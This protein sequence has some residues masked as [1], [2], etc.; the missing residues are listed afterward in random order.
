M[1]RNPSEDRK[2]VEDLHFLRKNH[3][4][5]S[6]LSWTDHWKVA[7]GKTFLDVVKVFNV[8]TRKL[9][10]FFRK[11]KERTHLNCGVNSQQWNQSINRIRNKNCQNTQSVDATW[12]QSTWI[13]GWWNE[14]SRVKKVWLQKTNYKCVCVCVCGQHEHMY[15]KHVHTQEHTQVTRSVNHARRWAER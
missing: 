13:V 8:T 11:S 6:E 10:T 5:R 3:D 2:Q 14:K 12:R 1:D 9:K 7:F 15:L 4:M